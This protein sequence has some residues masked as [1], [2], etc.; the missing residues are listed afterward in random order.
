M[1]TVTASS[2]LFLPARSSIRCRANASIIIVSNPPYIPTG[3]LAG[4]EPEV[5]DHEPR[6]AL[7]GGADGLDFYRRIIPAAVGQLLPEG[8]LLVEVGV[9]QAAAVKEMFAAN[10]FADIFAARDAGDR[11]RVVGGRI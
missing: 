5:R 9:D 6:A 8:W 2:S 10:K 4:L 1:P 11:E 7:D 3:D